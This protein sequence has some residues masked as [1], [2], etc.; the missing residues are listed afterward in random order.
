[1]GRLG[2]PRGHRARVPLA[3]RRL[4]VALPAHHQSLPRL[5]LHELRLL[6]LAPGRGARR[7]GDPLGIDHP[8]PLAQIDLRPGTRRARRAS[9][10]DGEEGR[11]ARLRPLHPL[12]LLRHARGGAF[13]G[14]GAPDFRSLPLPAPQ[15]ADQPRGEMAH[16]LDRAGAAQRDQ[17]GAGA[18]L[19]ARA[20]GLHAGGLA[21]A[22]GQAAAALLSRHPAQ[23]PG[24]AAAVL[25]PDAAEVRQ[26]RRAD[27]PRGRAPGEEGLP[28]HRRVR[29][30]LHPRDHL[31]RPPHLP[32]RQEGGLGGHGGDRRSQLD[33]EVHQQGLSRPS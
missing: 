27:G 26:A 15:G 10:E 7:A 8:R 16:H 31:A 32:L 6:L 29:R 33:P 3:P 5:R 4:H 2:P 1:M 9:R 17:G 14:P 25:H 13:P 18:A 20:R 28:P 12:C 23:P 21:P 24:A 11:Q 22:Q 30:A 19:R